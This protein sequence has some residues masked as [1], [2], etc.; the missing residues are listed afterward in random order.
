MAP[1]IFNLGTK[2][3]C[4][5][6]SIDCDRVGVVGLIVYQYSDASTPLLLAKMRRVPSGLYLVS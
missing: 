1:V 6:S 4:W 5:M 2:L 3:I